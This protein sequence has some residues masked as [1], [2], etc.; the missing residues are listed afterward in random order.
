MILES[1]C[2]AVATWARHRGDVHGL[3]LVGS[4]ARGAARADSDIDL[5]AIVT[6]PRSFRRSSDWIEEIGW[7]ARVVGWTDVSYGALWSRHCE[8]EDRTRVELGFSSPEWASCSPV[9][10]GTALVIRGG[11]TILHDPAGLLD[12]LQRSVAR[13]DEG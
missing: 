3:A 1:V 11:C 8:L 4:W 5:V 10:S 12:R 9:D 13:R 7:P 2:G 6:D